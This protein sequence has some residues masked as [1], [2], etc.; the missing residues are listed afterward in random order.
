VIN[1]DKIRNTKEDPILEIVLLRRTIKVLIIS[2]DSHV[3]PKIMSALA[4]DIEK[5]TTVP[6]NI[7][8]N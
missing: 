1:P 3:Y 8:K 5:F 6:L 7:L 4:R 2:K